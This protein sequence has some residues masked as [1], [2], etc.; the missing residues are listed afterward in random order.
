MLIKIKT[1]I[2]AY[3]F[4]THKINL[5]NLKM[6]RRNNSLMKWLKMAGLVVVGVMFHQT[7]KEWLN[8]VPVIG[9]LIDKN[10]Q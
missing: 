5:K 6:R 9:D 2:S 8:K 7:I 3:T 4:T 1:L 10:S